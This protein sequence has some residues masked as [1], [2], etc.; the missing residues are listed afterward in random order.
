[1]NEKKMVGNRISELLDAKGMTQSDLAKRAGITDVSMSRYV[2]GSR[3]PRASILA[4]IATILGTTSEYLL[5]TE[6]P[7]DFDTEYAK[8]H[9]L[10]ARNAPNMNMAQKRALVDAILTESND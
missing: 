2:N 3:T 1:M 5:G 8:I 4:N 10:I 6:T 9:R 7:A